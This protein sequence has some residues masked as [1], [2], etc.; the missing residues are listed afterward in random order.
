[1]KNESSVIRFHGR[2]I[3]FSQI[4]VDMC[5]WPHHFLQHLPSWSELSDEDRPVWGC[6]RAIYLSSTVEFTNAELHQVDPSDVPRDSPF[7]VG[8]IYLLRPWK[9]W[10]CHNWSA[11]VR[12]HG[13]GT[14]WIGDCCSISGKQ[15]MTWCCVL[16]L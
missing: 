7:S 16:I 3:V 9:G 14:D 12:C 10:L 13:S 5:L 4:E 2:F 6:E 15:L 8:S 11:F 1:M